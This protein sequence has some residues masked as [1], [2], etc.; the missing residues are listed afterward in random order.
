MSLMN[1]FILVLH[2]VRPAF[3]YESVHSF[4]TWY[5][6]DMHIWNAENSIQN[7]SQQNINPRTRTAIWIKTFFSLLNVAETTDEV[8]SNLDWP[9]HWNYFHEGW[10][11]YMWH[12]WCYFEA[13][14]RTDLGTKPSYLWTDW[15]RLDVDGRGGYWNNSNVSQGGKQSEN[16]IRR[17]RPARS[18]R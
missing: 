15:D 13:K 2:A 11:K 10:Q 5:P 6:W 3:S 18:P 7:G 4:A 1:V 9:V 17:Q 16:S 8:G 14:S 12:H